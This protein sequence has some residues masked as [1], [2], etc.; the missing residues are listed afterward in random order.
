M[1]SNINK[2]KVLVVGDLMLDES[3]FG[4]ASR[5][6]PEGPV[7]VILKSK[8]E[9][10]LG[11]AGFVA[12]VLS[13]LNID[14]TLVGIIGEDSI[15]RKVLDCCNKDKINSS[16]IINHKSY[17][18]T[19]KKR[20]YASGHLVAR[21]DDEEKFIMSNEI[22]EKCY[23]SIV[24]LFKGKDFKVCIISDYDKGFCDDSFI[25]SLI[26]LCN[27]YNVI[28]LVDPK[29]SDVEKFHSADLIKP[30]D[31]EAAK[32]L[33]LSRENLPSPDSV[34]K[35]I[36]KQLNIQ[37][38]LLTRG[39]QGMILYSD[40]KITNINAVQQDVFNVV[41][42]GDTV[43]AG[44]SAGLINGLS[45]K[46]SSFIA[47]DLAAEMISKLSRTTKPSNSIKERLSSPFDFD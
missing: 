38:I 30:N 11:G 9:T 42:A 5:L 14:V 46:E 17:K 32:I 12:R 10:T 44:L 26:K 4:T 29:T 41:G 3:I 28:T 23:K 31:N 39:A 24:N 40:K 34:A 2:T 43:L 25:K 27:K 22:R 33:G 6:T 45:I 15:S 1:K 21:L 37:N 19:N 7:P 35:D 47:N 20:I 8:T 13:D 18:T 16:L 36:S